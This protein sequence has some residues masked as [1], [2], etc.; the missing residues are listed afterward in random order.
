MGKSHFINFDSWY[1]GEMFV[2]GEDLE[3]LDGFKEDYAA[4]P[5]DIFYSQDRKGLLVRDIYAF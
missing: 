5:N 3:A 2:E 1:L 4:C